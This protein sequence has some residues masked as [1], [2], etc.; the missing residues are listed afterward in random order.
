MDP[1][2]PVVHLCS[3][4]MLAEAD[5]RTADARTHYEQAYHVAADDYEACIAAHYLARQQSTP[6]DS[7]RWNEECLRRAE[8]VGD[9]RV[10]AF[11]PS[12]H[13]NIA[14][15]YQQLGREDRAYEHYVLASSRIGDLPPDE[16]GDAVRQ[17]IADGLRTTAP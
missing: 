13:G 11:Y 7:L 17:A 9:D 12:L 8:L 4:G 14:H 3:E 15:A 10:R 1:Q 6:E 16:Y 5:G 2:N